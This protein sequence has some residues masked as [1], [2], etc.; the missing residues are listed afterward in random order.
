MIRLIEATKIPVNYLDKVKDSKCV[1]TDRVDTFD[2]RIVPQDEVRQ[3][4]QDFRR[5]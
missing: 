5:S 1:S 3:L 2:L 4:L